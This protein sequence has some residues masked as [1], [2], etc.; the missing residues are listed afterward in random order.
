MEESQSQ[1][2][3]SVMRRVLK[4]YGEGDV[5]PVKALLHADMVWTSHAPKEL[6]RIGGT[7]RGRDEAIA[8]MA[9]IAA[10]YQTHRYDVVELV[11]EGDVVWMSAVLDMTSRRNGAHFKLSIAS[12]WQFRDGMLVDLTEY[13]DLATVALLEG[14]ATIAV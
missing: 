4:A 9:M 1:S 6:F 8:G 11:G 3:K 12:R 7:H 10:D 13:Y 14:R 5:E 2:H